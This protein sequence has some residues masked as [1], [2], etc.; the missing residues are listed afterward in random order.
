MTAMLYAA[1]AETGCIRTWPASCHT[2]CFQ[3]I[4][5]F[6]CMYLTVTQMASQPCFA[7]R[8]QYSSTVKHLAPDRHVMS[9]APVCL[10]YSAALL[11]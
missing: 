6:D 2:A 11:S 1:A 4:L 7:L 10:L 3:C 5:V 8:A 9:S